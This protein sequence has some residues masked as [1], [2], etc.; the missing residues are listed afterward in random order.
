MGKITWFTRKL[1][2]RCVFTVLAAA[3]AAA[4]ASPAEMDRL[5]LEANRLYQTGN[6]QEALVNYSKI[7]QSGY[8]SGPLYYNMGNCYYKLSDIGRA[9][10]QY[11]RAKR[12]MPRDEDLK[13]NLAMANLATVDKIE[14]QADFLLIALV[15][16]FVHAIP[17]AP[18]IV[19]VLAFYVLGAA[20]LTVW[21]VSRTR[22]LRSLAFKISIVCAVLLAVS[23]LS[24]FA[25]ER[26]IR[27]RKESVILSDKVDVLS[28]PGGEGVEVFSLHTGTKVRTDQQ[29]GGWIEII[30]P[31]RKMGWVK[32]EVLEPI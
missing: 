5:F 12:L 17:A 30:L 8:E 2:N 24:L 3:L 18:L 31:D 20:F 16:G 27:L 14:P 4:S 23:G 15:N 6:Y 32:K 25:Q 19:L 10:L 26:G 28:A 11:E 29:T 9:I 21:V 1:R 13:A 7:V 22:W